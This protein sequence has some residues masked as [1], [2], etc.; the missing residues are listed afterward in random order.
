MTD[1]DQQALRSRSRKQFPVEFWGLDYI[2]KPQKIS[3]RPPKVV[4]VWKFIERDW[5]GPF[6]MKALSINVQVR[7]AYYLII[8]ISMRRAEIESSQDERLSPS[9]LVGALLQADPASG[10]IQHKC[11]TARDGFQ[12][13]HQLP[14]VARQSVCGGLFAPL[15]HSQ[16]SIRLGLRQ[17]NHLTPPT[18]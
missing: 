2:A 16:Q 17:V 3:E 9:V 5:N 12:R 14:P 4:R 10:D 8:G 18:A 1:T 11:L 13:Y 7:N 6:I 15:L